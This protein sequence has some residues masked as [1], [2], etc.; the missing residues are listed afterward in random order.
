MYMY[1]YIYGIFTISS[2]TLGR[3]HPQDAL[4]RRRARD[5]RGRSILSYN[6]SSSSSSSSS[7]NSSSSSS[8]ISNSIINISMI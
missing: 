6:I 8:S 2:P 3:Q 5:A 4:R 1:I 7:S